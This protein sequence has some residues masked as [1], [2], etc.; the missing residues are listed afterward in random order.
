MAPEDFTDIH[1]TGCECGPEPHRTPAH[2]E[3]EACFVFTLS[4]APDE[5]W[6]RLFK[7]ALRE[8]SSDI[9]SFELHL[10]RLR[11]GRLTVF[12]HPERLQLYADRLKGAVAKANRYRRDRAEAGDDLAAR[13]REFE[14]MIESSLARLEL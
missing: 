7:D 5:E 12:C 10:N 4:P 2:R 6:Q 3:W 11:G 1:V 13:R 14:R 8:S 9:V